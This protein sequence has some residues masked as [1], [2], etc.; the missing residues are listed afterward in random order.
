MMQKPIVALHLRAKLILLYFLTIFIPLLIMGQVILSVSG[1]KIIEQTTNLSRESSVQTARNVQERF[2]GYV[3][4]V[5]RLSVDQALI[6]YLNPARVYESELQSIDAYDLY[7]KP[8]TFYDFNHKDPA[9]K[10]NILFLN[11]TLLQDL[12]IFIHADEEV[13]LREDYQAAVNAE[14]ALVWGLKEEGIFVARSVY[15]VKRQLAAVISMQ[16]PESSLHS[17]ISET[18]LSDRTLLIADRSGHA[19]SSNDRNLIGRSVRDQAYF[20]PDAAV[21]FDFEDPVTGRP[22]K[23]IVETLGDGK[24][25]PDWRLLTLIPLDRLIDDERHIRQIGLWV[26]ALGLAVSCGIFLIAL[27]RITERVKRLVKKMQSVKTGELS[28]L[29]DDVSRDEIGAL[30]RSFNGMIENLQRS[31]YENYEVN[32]KLKDITIKKQEAELYALQNQIHPH[33]LFNTLESIRM[34]LHNKGDQ[35]TATVVLHFSNLFRHLLNWQGEFIPLRDEVDLI[36]KYLK[37]Q[38]YRFRDRIRDELAMDERLSG[39]LIPKLT[40][41]PLVENAVKHG[42]ENVHSGSIRV[43]IRSVGEERMEA[44]IEDDGAGIPEDRL[45]E[46]RGELADP[47]IKKSGSIGLKNVHDRIQLHYGAGYGVEVG[48]GSPK[49]TRVRVTM[50][51]REAGGERDDADGAAE[52]GGGKHVQGVDRG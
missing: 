21:P 18:R 48:K 45:N 14:G 50:P 52:G 26:L 47:E 36:R 51:I 29:E 1:K 3:D 32:L 27:G 30:T 49:G 24:I 23:V 13:R 4:I 12:N 40:L 46:I 34:G 38:K 7:L 28:V 37:V 43:L 22:Y 16:F 19:I 15:T 39:V 10:L 8:V 42:I 25:F 9:A 41:Q 5:G 2:G 20:R 31:I 11:D 17:L 44:V 33:F 35:E 6:N